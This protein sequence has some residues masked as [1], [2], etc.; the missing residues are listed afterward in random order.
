[1][2]YKLEIMQKASEHLDQLLSYLL[3]SLKSGQAAKQLLSGIEK[4]Y[5]RLEEES[6]KEDLREIL[7]DDNILPWILR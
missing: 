4:V 3:D 6:Y 5:D 1:M 2:G 7:L